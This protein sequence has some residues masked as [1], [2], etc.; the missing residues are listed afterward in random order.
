MAKQKNNNVG[1]TISISFD[2]RRLDST[3]KD[4]GP[5][6]TLTRIANTLDYYKTFGGDQLESMYNQV[7]SKLNEYGET[8][9]VNAHK[10]VKNATDFFSNERFFIL[11]DHHSGLEEELENL[12]I[13]PEI[14]ENSL[15]SEKYLGTKGFNQIIPIVEETYSLTPEDLEK[16]VKEDLYRVDQ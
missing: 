3:I 16:V 15:K 5:E 2:N 12:T 8:R 4:F 11:S 9:E 10:S 1:E 13:N 6:L 7:E 14:S